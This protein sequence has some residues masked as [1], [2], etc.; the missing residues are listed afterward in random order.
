MATKYGWF[1]ERKAW[2]ITYHSFHQ[3]QSYCDDIRAHGGTK[4]KDWNI[5]LVDLGPFTGIRSS[6][7]QIRQDAETITVSDNTPSG[8]TRSRN[9]YDEAQDKDMRDVQD[10]SN[11]GDPISVDGD[12]ERSNLKAGAKHSAE[13]SGEP[14]GFTAHIQEFSGE[15]VTVPQ[16]S[17]KVNCE[18][19][20]ESTF[21]FFLLAL[22]DTFETKI[23]SF[24]K[25]LKSAHPL[26]WTF[27]RR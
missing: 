2:P 7:Y 22:K 26:E 16:T 4:P 11:D 12:S 23:Q 1:L 21:I 17:E 20:I 19:L 27:S 13:T 24:A 18:K 14:G 10:S 3:F 6:Q 9:T 25:K 15:S 8:N 5:N